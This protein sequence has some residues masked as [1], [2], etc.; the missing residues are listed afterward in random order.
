MTP[1]VQFQ[2][3]GL[4]DYKEAWDYQ[5][6]LFKGTIDEKIRIR[7]GESDISTKNYLLFCE[8]PQ[9]ARQVSKCCSYT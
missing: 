3:L 5:E 6:Q 2:S 4:I 1:I 8:H 7:N 9:T